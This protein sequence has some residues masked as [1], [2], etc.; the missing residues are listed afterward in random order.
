MQ[1]TWTAEVSWFSIAEMAHE[2]ACFERQRT[3]RCNC[4]SGRKGNKYNPCD[5]AIGIEQNAIARGCDEP[6][7]N[8]WTLPAI[9]DWLLGHGTCNDARQGKFCKHRA[10]DRTA[11]LVNWLEGKR[12]AA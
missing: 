5:R 2:K 6:L 9:V 4:I 11:H 10:C 1:T 8:E 12:K 3:G 7:P